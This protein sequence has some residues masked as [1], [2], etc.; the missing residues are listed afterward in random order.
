[1][2]FQTFKIALRTLKKN[3]LYTFI[4]IFGLTIGIAA[5]LLIFRMVNYEMGFNKDFANYDRIVRTVS[6]TPSAGGDDAFGYCMPIPAMEMMQ[7]DITPFEKT[8]RIHETWANLTIPNPSGGAPLKKFK[9]EDA[10]TAMFV[11]ADFL[12]IFDFELLSGDSKSVLAEPNTILLTKTWAQKCFDD[13]QTAVGQTVL[14]DNLVAVKVTGILDDLP[15]NCDFS[16][17][18]LVSYETA[19]KNQELFFY[20]EASWGSCSSNDQFY[21]LLQDANQWEAAEKLLL[22]VGKKEYTNDEG[23]QQKFFQLQALSDLHYDER[24]GHSGTHMVSKDRLKVL[25]FI[26]LLIL[27]IACFNFINLATA[28][29]TL[30]AK[31][32]GVRKTLGSRPLDLIGQFMS[33]TGLI[34]LISVILGANLAMIAAP[35]LNRVSDVPDSLPFLTDPIMVTFLAIL[36]IVVTLLSGLYPAFQ[37][38]R[39]RPVEAL[40]SKVA[41]ESFGGISLR[42][43]LV[44]AQFVIAQALII[45]ALITINQLDYIRSKDL[46]FAKDL[47]YTFG[48]NSDEETV[49]RQNALKQRLLQIPEVESVTLNSDQPFSGSTW[50][51]NFYYNNRPDDE[52]FDISLKFADAD[53]AETFGI[54]ILEGRW[55]NPSDT[56]REGVLN[57]TTV[58]MLGIDN[59]AEVI[60]QR[61]RLGRKSLNI[62]GVMKDFH[63]HSL[64]EDIEPLMMTTRKDYYWEAGVKI[65]PMDITGTTAAI[66]RVYDEVLPEQVFDGTFFDENIA[67]FY[68]DDARLSATCRGFG[69][70]AILISC[71]GLFG[72]ATHA[73]NQRIKEI[74]IRKVL[75]ASTVG[76]VSLLSKDFLKL[77]VIALFLAGPIAWMVMTEWLNNFEFRVDIGWPIFVFSGGIAVLIAF[78]TVS[79][80]AIRAAT[81]N[82]IKAIKT[83]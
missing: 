1:M 3:P 65:R 51:S 71:L 41:K 14:L 62:V 20:N 54:E 26:G 12:E 35:L 69:L 36:A 38:S 47:V 60:G 11:D 81:S 10:Q 29:A 53:Y 68:E 55:F 40:K 83:E 39:Y 72:L 31:E 52:D 70:L 43:G 44:I 63:A 18:Y 32:V 23:E 80:Q 76:I 24:Y 15:T 7:A 56:M 5:V 74:G 33:E 8:A 46:G 19:E 42:K 61:I 2:H 16:F 6:Y 82:P 78:L 49:T 50:M 79:Y 48:F 28:Q 21:A 66:Q 13:W 37:L 64:H 58:R 73:A 4:N 30:R 57:E 17:P 59:P 22:N 45:G 25:G 67:Q 9:L 34:V 77:V 27:V 75:G